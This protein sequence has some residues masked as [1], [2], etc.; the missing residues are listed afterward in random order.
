VGKDASMGVFHV[1]VEDILGADYV[2][3]VVNLIGAS[4]DVE[5][6]PD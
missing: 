3:V 4:I 2:K 1:K 5:M 6:I